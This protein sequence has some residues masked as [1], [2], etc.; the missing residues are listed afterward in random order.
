MI[1]LRRIREEP[2]RI[3]ELL[4]TRDPDIC[5]DEILALDAERRSVISEVE[6]LKAE[7]NVG[8]QEVGRLKREGENADVLLESLAV[9]SD[10]VAAL[11]ATLREK[12]ER[13]DSLLKL[14]PNIPHESVPVG[15]KDDYVV[16]KMVGEKPEATFPIRNHLELAESKGILDFPRAA[17]IAG[18]GFPMYV[19]AA[20]KLEMAL[21][22][23]MFFHHASR[24]YTPVLPPFVANEESFYLSL[25]H[26]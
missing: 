18:S 20:A 2:K 5:L 11:D 15:A 26:I 25:I 21:I 24:G 19:G 22:Q 4:R 7:R 6:Q 23:F 13:I 1:D 10:R 8:S 3:Q 16:A 9:L 14:L 12:Q 17:A